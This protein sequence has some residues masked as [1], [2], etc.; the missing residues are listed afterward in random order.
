MNLRPVVVFFKY[1]FKAE[2]ELVVVA[3]SKTSCFFSPQKKVVALRPSP[4]FVVPRFLLSWLM[5]CSKNRTG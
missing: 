2:T 3:Y 1:C 5:K 4:L